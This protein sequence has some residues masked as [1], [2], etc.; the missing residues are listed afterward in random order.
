MHQ[1]AKY[2]PRPRPLRGTDRVADTISTSIL[3]QHVQRGK[4]Q[5]DLNRKCMWGLLMVFLFFQLY[6]YFQ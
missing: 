6:F 3:Q 5:Q 2:F 4:D 1:H